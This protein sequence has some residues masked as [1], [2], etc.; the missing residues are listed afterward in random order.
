MSTLSFI[1]VQY[2]SGFDG[3]AIRKPGGLPFLVSYW[4]PNNLPDLSDTSAGSPTQR[5]RWI[6]I[7]LAF[8]HRSYISS[9]SVYQRLPCRQFPIMHRLTQTLTLTLFSLL[10]PAWRHTSPDTLRSLP[11]VVGPSSLMTLLC[12]AWR[13]QAP[14]TKGV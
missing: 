14:R 11:L 3:S 7:H 10:I 5:S 8:I 9:S 4:D 6:N 2:T 12:H 13:T 1:L